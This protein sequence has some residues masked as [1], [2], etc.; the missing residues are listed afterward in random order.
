MPTTKD[1]KRVLVLIGKGAANYEYF[2]ATLNDPS[3]IQPLEKHRI[4]DDP[5][6]A[7]RD[8]NDRVIG[9][10]WWPQSQYLARVASKAPQEVLAIALKIRTDNFFVM[11][12]LTKA[13]LGMPVSMA[14]KW[15]DHITKWLRR[16][17]IIL[18]GLEGDLGL[19][20]SK[21]AI[22]NKADVALK[23]AAEILAVLPDPEAEKKAHPK[24]KAERIAFSSLQPGI[25]CDW[26]NYEQLLKNNI[27]ALA[28]A[29][30]FETLDL[31]C[32][33][34]S[35]A[36]LYSLSE[37]DNK[38]T[39]DSTN[40][41]RPAVEDHEQNDDDT[42]ICLLIVAIRDM[43]EKICKD[44]ADKIG[45]VVRKIEGFGWD[46]FRRIGL[47]LL[48]VSENPPMALIEER[49]VNEKY[50]NYHGVNHEYFHLMKKYFG[51][52]SKAGQETLLQWI[53][54][55][56][57]LSDRDDLNAERK[58]QRRKYVQYR[59]LCAIKDYLTA[60]WKARFQ[61]LEKEIGERDIPPDFHTWMFPTT[62]GPQSPKASEDLAE[63]SMD[64]L[65]DYLKNWK[66]SGEWTAPTPD[67]LG[68]A[69]GSLV[70]EHPDK[71]SA[72]IERF[73]DKDMDPTY[74]RHLISGFCRAVEGKKSIPFEPVFRLC[75][76]V[77][78]QPV[79]IAGRKVPKHLREDF[80]MDADWRSARIE[81][82]RL[83]EKL[84][85][86][87][88]GLPYDLREAIW[89][90][91]EPLTNDSEPS[92][93]YEAKHGGDKMDPLTVSINTTRGKALHAAMHYAMWICRQIKKAENRA[94]DFTDP[95]LQKVREV[96]DS[97]LDPD[98]SP[99][100]ANQ[101]DRAVYGHWLPQLVHVDAE[102]VRTNLNRL[103]PTEPENRRLREATWDTYLTYSNLYTPVY[104]I[105]RNVYREEVERL[106]E[107]S[108]KEDSSRTPEKRLV[109][110]V[111]V[112]YV[113]GKVGLD[114]ND[115]VDVLFRKAPEELTAYAMDFIGRSMNGRGPIE[116]E[117][118]K[119]F[120]ALWDWRAKVTED[121][122]T[123][124][125]KEL[126]AFGWWFASGLFDDDWTFPYFETVLKRTLINQSKRYVFEHMSRVF[127]DHSK[128]SLQ[129]LR[130]FIEKN[131][132]PWFLQPHMKTGVLQ[133]LEQGVAHENPEIRE[134][135]VDIVHLL[136][137]KG[138]LQYR[139]LL[140]TISETA[141]NT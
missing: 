106:A 43:A 95:E 68:S 109:E 46:I 61:A 136:G 69:L 128:E 25:R 21:L 80:E 129:C 127:K 3:W 27:P 115:L 137:S 124:L 85:E 138:Y 76:W 140:K 110:H 9:A 101:T 72:L 119:K 67:G 10:S 35:N 77:V 81:I 32:K 141:S 50:F 56:E 66:P 47:H 103:F 38:K 91:L 118:V 82:A 99:F 121:M 111:V 126:S 44:Q 98:K 60:E 52:L 49:L 36:I 88:L 2:F 113:R 14:A 94:P 105:V 8:A 75:K 132:D 112:L 64:D 123:M 117:A 57:D 29:A 92:L 12:D 116:S 79:K 13:A 71:Y 15:A 24:N 100:A 11:S 18:G 34:L 73:M 58:E 59:N 63:M 19:L 28:T 122:K 125:D 87:K 5:P 86:D 97:H 16:E 48:R 104:D 51:S 17:N 135:A 65:V 33:L 20:F 139:V 78:D 53:D 1:I 54:K 37:G 4:F 70:A 74:V 133:V 41:W 7:A 39:Y 130:L 42:I 131:D 84:F 107:K 40:V 114:D 102:W 89:R 108:V 83:N 6:S 30:P 90:I 26:Y 93:E 62:I 96:L 120:K 23:L 134:A 22:Q 31:L 45:E 55:G